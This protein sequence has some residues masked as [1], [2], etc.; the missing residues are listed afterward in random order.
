MIIITGALGFIASNLI[1]ALNQ[2]GFTDLV[3]VDDFYKWKKEKNL[4]GKRI[5]EWVHR[6][7]FLSYFEK[8]AP[9]E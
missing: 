8:I 1:T 7:L 3:V 4:Q 5:L 6:D 2:A 9:R